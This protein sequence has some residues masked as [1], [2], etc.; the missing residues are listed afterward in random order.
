MGGEEMPGFLRSTPVLLWL[1]THAMVGY[2][3][4]P[5][6]DAE[7]P[8]WKLSGRDGYDAETVTHWRWLPMPPERRPNPPSGQRHQAHEG[9]NGLDAGRKKEQMDS[10]LG[11]MT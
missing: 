10:T 6:D 7:H 3:Q 11:G 2:L 1:G 4:A 9:A 8:Q 5:D